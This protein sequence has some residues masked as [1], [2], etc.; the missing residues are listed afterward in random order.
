MKADVKRDNEGNQ[1]V[2]IYND[3]GE[4]ISEQVTRV[5]PVSDIPVL[6]KKDKIIQIQ[7]SL[8]YL[9]NY[10]ECFLQKCIYNA[11]D[12]FGKKELIAMGSYMNEDSFV[13]DIGA[14]IGNHTLYFAN[15]CHVRKIYAFEPVPYTYEVL[16][17]N[18]EINRLENKVSTFCMGMSDSVT[19]AV[20]KIY[21]L[22]N[23]GGTRLKPAETGGIKLVTLDSLNIDEKIDFIKIDVET[24]DREVL[25][26]SKETIIKYKPVVCVESFDSEY[27]ETKA[28]LESLGYK[29]EHELPCCE[30]IFIPV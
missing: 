20:I 14:N 27:K 1:T 28:F 4:V 19:D 24:M 26:G 2:Y 6:D 5:N 13:I 12:Y 23:I 3:E 16:V 9:P 15:E 29:L 21:D 8:F 25:H 11:N 10:D 30:Y 18:I 7:N 17:K 22:K